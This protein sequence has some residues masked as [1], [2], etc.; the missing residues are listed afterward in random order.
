MT[1]PAYV[2]FFQSDL[3][4]L[5][6]IL[7]ILILLEIFQIFLIKNIVESNGILLHTDSIVHSTAEKTIPINAKF[8]PE[9]CVV[10][11]ISRKTS[12]A[13][14]CFSATPGIEMFG[15]TD[16]LNKPIAAPKP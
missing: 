8:L 9:V 15:F 3:P 12:L 4:R 16:E 14:C 1:P 13:V 7:S 2:P 10:A 6:K 11:R 5:W